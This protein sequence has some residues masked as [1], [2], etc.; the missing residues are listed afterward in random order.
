[1]R[2]E[3]QN[4]HVD[5]QQAHA[6][7]QQARRD[8][9][10]NSGPAFGKDEIKAADLPRFTGSHK[11]L[12]GWIMAC[13]LGIASQPSKFATEGKKV[14]WAVSFLDGPL[15][16]WAQPL[17]NAYLLGPESPPPQELASFDALANALRALF[18]DPNLER[19]AIAALNNLRQ[20]TSVAEY[21]TRFAGHSQH[22]KM[23]GNALAP[24][25]YRGLKDTIK[26]LLAGQEEWRTFEELQDQASRLDAHLQVRKIEREQET[27]IHVAPPMK[28][29]MK[30][31]YDSKPTFNPK[32]AFIP[33][34]RGTP[35]AVPCPPLAPAHV[36][37]TP[38][39]LDSQ[40]RRM[41][42]EEHDRCIRGALCFTCK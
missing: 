28:I 27:R 11:E 7:A 32:P 18:G 9:L 42:Q 39:E 4:A 34:T 20:T 36:G 29:E 19:N 31:N 3:L 16:S 1:M 5:V 2:I 37:P 10:Q 15:R 21:R 13:C 25:F 33:A 8:A 22:M 17:I 35:P 12:E 41:S 6:E 38:M 30:P 40:N 24:Y 14:I 23:D 26:D